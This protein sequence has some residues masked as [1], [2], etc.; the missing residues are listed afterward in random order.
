MGAELFAGPFACALILVCVTE[1]VMNAVMCLVFRVT[2]WKQL[3]A[4]NVL[5][6]MAELMAYVFTVAT[7]TLA[8]VSVQLLALWLLFISA[9]VIFSAIWVTYDEYPEVWLG[10]VAFYNANLGPFLS[11][12][13]TIPLEL[14]DVL[15]RAFIPLW[16]AAF[17]WAKALV[18]QVI[19]LG[20]TSRACLTHAV[21]IHRVC[22]LQR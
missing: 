21:F 6:R 14:A 7:R 16:D 22:C 2:P 8:R 17:W 10:F 19:P 11:F 9:F 13:F 12:V 20:C 18:V 5:V 15:L 4:Q 3:A 1:R